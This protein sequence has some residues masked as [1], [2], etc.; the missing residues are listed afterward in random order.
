MA[1]TPENRR[2]LNMLQEAQRHAARMNPRWEAEKIAKGLE[3][4]QSERPIAPVIELGAKR[5][6]TE[7]VLPKNQEVVIE[8]KAS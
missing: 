8:K 3:F 1:L 7:V 5:V 4:K 6:S 2:N